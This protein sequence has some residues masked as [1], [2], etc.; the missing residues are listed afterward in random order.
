[1][2]TASSATAPA[3]PA[4]VSAIVRIIEPVETFTFSVC[5]RSA[6]EL[7]EY[8]LMRIGQIGALTLIA[9]FGGAEIAVGRRSVNCDNGAPTVTR[10][11]TTAEQQIADLL[12]A[13]RRA[14]GL[15]VAFL[16][17][18][19]ATTQHLD[20]VES[21]VPILFQEGVVLDRSTSLCQAI[22]DGRL[23]AV[24]SNLTQHPEAMA[25]PAARLPR[26]RSYVSVPVRL[27][28]GQLYGTFCV[29]GL[30]PES[31]LRP[32]DRAVMDVL[33][34][35]AAAIIEPE[36]DASLRA[37]EIAARLEPVIARG[38]PAIAL[39]PIVDLRTGVRVGA[40]ALAR[41][42]ADWGKAPDVVFAEAH[43]I[44]LGGDLEVL[45][46]RRA[47]DTL[48]T[49]DGYVAINLSP[50]TL[51]LD[52]C[53][54]ILEDAP[55]GRLVVELSEHDPVGDYPL[56]GA[57]LGRHRDDGL[58]LAVDDVGAGFSSLRHIVLT[59]P[60]IMKLDRTLVDGVHRDAVL[61][62]LVRSMVSFADGVGARVVAEGIESADDA[63]ALSELGVDFGQGWFFGRPM[64]AADLAAIPHQRMP[65]PAMAALT[66]AG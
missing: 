12:V 60:D 49:V 5:G 61:R 18:L 19:E 17:R 58:R 63:K 6:P 53:Q 27:S 3:A 35:A 47:L 64:P 42:P 51:E 24:I 66:P 40:E 4:A 57:L 31:K 37:T 38:G 7:D 9:P 22:L 33:A 32:R 36:I 1:V 48:K 16:S 28:D 10:T 65:A 62:S 15:S 25:L 14:L 52:A 59:S 8:S 21:T 56:L 23:P 55:R 45:A 44:G 13:A 43:E 50:A 46:M 30:R 11:R 20:V 26:I 34:Q 39:Q 54:Q 2:P 41:F 29:C